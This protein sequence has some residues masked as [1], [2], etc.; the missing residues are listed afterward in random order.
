LRIKH[1]PNRFEYMDLATTRVAADEA[2]T[3]ELFGTD[4]ARAYIARAE[5]VREAQA[6]HAHNVAPMQAAE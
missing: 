5:R 1:D 3:H 6:G 2:E 4:A